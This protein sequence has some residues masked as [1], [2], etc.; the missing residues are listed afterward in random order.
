MALQNLISATISDEL[1]SSIL[2]KL[3]SIKT[4][5]S[6][7]ITMLPENKNEYLKVGNVMLPF[8]DKVY[9]VVDTH[10]E[11][12]SNVFDKDEFKKDYRLTKDLAPVSSLISELA[13]AIE[14]TLYAANS[15]TMVE[16]LEIYAAV[17]QNKDKVPGMDVIAGELKEFFK[18]SKRQSTAPAQK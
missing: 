16:A 9:S 2:T 13:S 4:D 5:L 11:I 7:L 1:K 3:N 14:A 12:L 15:D 17:Q 10:P 6:F 8:L 18:R